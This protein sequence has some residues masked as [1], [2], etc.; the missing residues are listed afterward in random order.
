MPPHKKVSPSA[1]FSRSRSTEKTNPTISQLEIQVDLNYLRSMHRIYQ[2]NSFVQAMILAAEMLNA[3]EKKLPG[4]TVQL[5]AEDYQFSEPDLYECARV[6][7]YYALTDNAQVV[8]GCTTNKKPAEILDIIKKGLF[9]A[10]F[11]PAES[12]LLIYLVLQTGGGIPNILCGSFVHAISGLVDMERIGCLRSGGRLL[13]A[14]KNSAGIG[15]VMA[16]EICAKK[17]YGTLTPV[18]TCRVQLQIG[19]RLVITDA[20]ITV[21]NSEMIASIQPHFSSA[22]FCEI[23]GNKAVYY[24][25]RATIAKLVTEERK[26]GTKDFMSLA[27]KFSEI[28]RADYVSEKNGKTEI[29][30]CLDVLDVCMAYKYEFE[31]A[32]FALNKLLTLFQQSEAEFN[33]IVV[34][35]KL[36]SLSHY[37]PDIM[38][39]VR[40][41][42]KQFYQYLMSLEPADVTSD[43]AEGLAAIFA[44]L[45]IESPETVG[46][47]INASEV[48]R[49]LISLSCPTQTL[50]DHFLQILSSNFSKADVL[51]EHLRTLCERATCHDQYSNAMDLIE[52]H[53]YVLDLGSSDDKGGPAD[54]ALDQEF[55]RKNKEQEIDARDKLTQAILQEVCKCLPAYVQDDWR[56][57]VTAHWEKELHWRLKSH[58]WPSEL[59]L[60]TFFLLSDSDTHNRMIISIM[61]WISAFK[62]SISPT[63]VPPL[64]SPR[65]PVTGPTRRSLFS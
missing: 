33:K 47:S 11:E 25:N 21:T 41:Y 13:R 60:R 32:L 16:E 5:S 26:Y 4:I 15:L 39:L 9:M 23:E 6:P 51:L 52:A 38:E 35:A 40:L 61:D 64:P 14:I 3:V 18:A 43:N 45:V 30:L 62:H 36:F 12:N 46:L 56:E 59:F 44:V 34:A 53:R 55:A 49:V 28:D 19:A 2:Q 63:P 24:L 65:T 17:T 57:R 27:Q 58:C 20:T 22:W 31:L 29:A 1:F 42:P 54:S 8:L 7:T 37:I 48:I 50:I 10:D